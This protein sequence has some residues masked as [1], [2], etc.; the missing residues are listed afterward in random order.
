MK[1]YMHDSALESDV[2]FDSFDI[3]ENDIDGVSCDRGG[4]TLFFGKNKIILKRDEAGMVFA[5]IAD[6]EYLS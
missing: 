4:I 2:D 1:I 3:T 5:A 6:A